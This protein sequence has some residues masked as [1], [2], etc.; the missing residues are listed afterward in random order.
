MEKL[1]YDF[2]WDK[3][4]SKIKK[5]IVCAKYEMGGLKM[6][7]VK[8]FIS[9]MKIK[10]LSRINSDNYLNKRILTMLPELRNIKEVGGTFIKF[11]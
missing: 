3:K 10:W 4:P 6:P 8:S 2:L 5:T 7:D 9:S 11:T 1:F